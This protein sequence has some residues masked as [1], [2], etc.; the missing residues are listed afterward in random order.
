MAAAMKQQTAAIAVIALMVFAF[1]S[2]AHA[3]RWE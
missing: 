3:G 2:D 1:A